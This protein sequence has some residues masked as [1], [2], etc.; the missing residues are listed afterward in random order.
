[1]LMVD[2]DADLLI[3]LDDVGPIIKYVAR[4]SPR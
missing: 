3:T 4:K 2:I 1:M